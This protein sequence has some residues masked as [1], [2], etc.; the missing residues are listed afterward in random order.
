M[1]YFS[2][3]FVGIFMNRESLPFEK[4]VILSSE[5][6]ALGWDRKDLSALLLL[7]FTLYHYWDSVRRAA[8]ALAWIVQLGMS[9]WK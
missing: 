2:M 6:T 8:G 4:A 5:A 3:R 7:T 9:F 1:L